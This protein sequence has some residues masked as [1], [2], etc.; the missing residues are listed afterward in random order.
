M[1]A[2]LRFSRV[3]AHTCHLR[4]LA[5]TS[6]LLYRVG[7]TGRGPQAPICLGDVDDSAKT[8]L[9]KMLSLIYLLPSSSSSS[10]EWFPAV[11]DMMVD[12]LEMGVNS[13]L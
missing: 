2:Q 7:D 10:V 8:L 3:T 9:G 12:I 11:L 6:C 1:H 5:A 4:T 13:L